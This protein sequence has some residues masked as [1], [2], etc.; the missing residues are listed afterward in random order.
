VVEGTYELHDKMSDD[1]LQL[2]NDNRLESR[3]NIKQVVL[4][5][6]IKY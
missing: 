3:I 1:D 6:W 5:R 4:L 2:K